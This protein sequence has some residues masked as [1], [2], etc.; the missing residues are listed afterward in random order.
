M[1]WRKTYSRKTQDGYER[2]VGLFKTYDFRV[3]GDS[4]ER[5]SIR[6]VLDWAQQ[7]V[8][9]Q[10]EQLGEHLSMR[11]RYGENPL[12]MIRRVP[13]QWCRQ[14]KNQLRKKKKNADGAS[15]KRGRGKYFD[16]YPEGMKQCTEELVRCFNETTSRD[17]PE[18][19][20]LSTMITHSIQ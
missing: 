6:Q 4:L 13:R 9:E 5:R 17:P 2:Q 8:V 11:G 12:G 14:M 1:R 7:S 10:W 18:A 3:F 15:L 19:P 16:L 20:R